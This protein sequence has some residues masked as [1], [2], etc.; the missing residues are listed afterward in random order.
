MSDQRRPCSQSSRS[1]T[2]SMAD[3]LAEAASPWVRRWVAGLSDQSDVL[4]LACGNGR[5]LALLA[6]L[7]HWVTGVDRDVAA[8]RGPRL[9]GVVLIE[10]D[11]EQGPWPLP[12]RQFDAVVVTNYLWRPL[13]PTIVA[14]VAVGGLLVYE[15][16][17][18][19]HEQYGRPRNPDFLLQPDELRQAVSGQLEVME[20][21]QGPE[22]SPVTAVRQRLAARRTEGR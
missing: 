17:M 19:G 1:P 14:S 18:V 16:F 2:G 11:L 4:D 12:G 10:A 8:A 6:S 21:A 20:F 22:G 5:H 13:L 3:Q 15:T 9:P 7:G